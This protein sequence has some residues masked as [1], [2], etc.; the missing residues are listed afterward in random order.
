MIYVVCGGLQFGTRPHTSDVFA[1]IDKAQHGLPCYRSV[2]LGFCPGQ[3]F[4]G[5]A[6][7]RLESENGFEW[8]ERQGTD[9]IPN[10]SS[11]AFDFRIVFDPSSDKNWLVSEV[12]ER[13]LEYLARDSFLV[14]SVAR[15]TTFNAS[16]NALP[17]LK[18][19][20]GV[21][22]LQFRTS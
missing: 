3:G 19:I 14:T 12:L 20:S 5:C 16:I 22:S 9:L 10:R 15:V 13:K 7:G 2:T 18:H 11:I 6:L 21:G 8:R 4:Q 1:R 17:S